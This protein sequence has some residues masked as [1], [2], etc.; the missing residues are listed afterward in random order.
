MEDTRNNIG[1]VE[2]CARLAAEAAGRDAKNKDDGRTSPPP[3]RRAIEALGGGITRWI[4]YQPR[5]KICQILTKNTNNCEQGPKVLG[6]FSYK[7]DGAS[8]DEADCNRGEM[9]KAMTFTEANSA[10]SASLPLTHNLDSTWKYEDR[11]LKDSTF[12][13]ARVGLNLLD[14]GAIRTKLMQWDSQTLGAQ[15]AGRVTARSNVNLNPI[16]WGYSDGTQRARGNTPPTI[17]RKKIKILPAVIYPTSPVVSCDVKVGDKIDPDHSS[18]DVDID[19]FRV[20]RGSTAA[21]PVVTSAQGL[22]QDSDLISQLVDYFENYQNRNIAPVQETVQGSKKTNPFWPGDLALLAYESKLDNIMGLTGEEEPGDNTDTNG[23]VANTDAFRNALRAYITNCLEDTARI[24][25]AEMIT[26]KN[27]VNAFETSQ[28]SKYGEVDVPWRENKQAADGAGR[29]VAFGHESS[30]GLFTTQHKFRCAVRLSDKCET[31]HVV[32]GVESN[33]VGV[34]VLELDKPYGDGKVDSTGETY[35]TDHF[36]AT[37]T[38]DYTVLDAL[39][40]GLA[41]NKPEIRVDIVG[42]GFI[43]G[44]EDYECTWKMSTCSVQDSCVKELDRPGRADHFGIVSCAQPKWY[45]DA[46]AV[47]VTMTGPV[48]EYQG[49]YKKNQFSTKTEQLSKNGLATCS[50]A[51]Q[52]QRVPKKRTVL[53]CLDF[54]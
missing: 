25:N 14:D 22:R 16:V 30:H 44:R 28:W 33:E 32:T 52:Q 29:R 15:G 41:G 10:T 17:D 2:T 26:L 46:G 27:A 4:Q 50:E 49:C 6:W 7:V 8:W 1:D 23:N 36:L 37:G 53:T 45:G 24:S 31:G 3:T 19:M 43:K 42:A 12:I 54:R 5:E 40:N 39:E 51:P 48:L 11:C 21:P 18:E 34:T 38:D 35:T 47:E 13:K 9:L 20:E